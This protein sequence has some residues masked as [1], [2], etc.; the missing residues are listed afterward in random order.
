MNQRIHPKYRLPHDLERPRR[1]K[2]QLAA[3][4][5]H[6]ARN[7]PLL[8]WRAL[9]PSHELRPCCPAQYE[10][11]RMAL[12]VLRRGDEQVVEH[13]DLRAYPDHKIWQVVLGRRGRDKLNPFMRWAEA[14]TR[15]VPEG[16]RL[17]AVRGCCPG[18]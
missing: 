10:R 2:D 12:E 17:A 3:L 15:D 8:L 14:V 6:S 7:C 4:S 18:G 5:L 11:L 9:T 13:V 16:A 1:H